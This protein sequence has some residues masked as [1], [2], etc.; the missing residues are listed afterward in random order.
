MVYHSFYF[1]YHRCMWHRESRGAL[2]LAATGSVLSVNPDRII[3]KRI[4]II[5]MCIRN[6]C[7]SEW[8]D[9]RYG[10]VLYCV[11]LYCIVCMYMYVCIA[12]T[13]VLCLWTL[14]KRSLCTS[15]EP[16]SSALR[17]NCFIAWNDE[18]YA[19]AHFSYTLSSIQSVPLF[20]RTSSGPFDWSFL[21]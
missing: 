14:H 10:T 6:L 4:R 13:H 5:G 20:W 17:W 1:F 16:Q 11:E 2:R 9:C 8:F 19:Q 3:V 18:S 15:V 21:T 7:P 12:C